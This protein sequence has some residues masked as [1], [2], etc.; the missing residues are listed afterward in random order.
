LLGLPPS[1]EDFTKWIEH[2]SDDWYEQLVSSLL[3]SPHYG[4]RMA[5]RWMD[6][7]RYAD[8]KGYV[9]QE[10]REYPHAYRYRDWL[11]RAF[12]SDL[13][14]DEFI[15]YQ[16]IADQLD[17]QNANG[18]LDAMGMLTLGRRFLQ[19]KN[20]MIESTFFAVAC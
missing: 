4:E 9:F 5:R 19:N 1:L 6:V 10:D 20:E 2:E 16:L 8:N 3:E 7:V 13:G 18:H 14:Y 11:I 17:P 15:R 12:N